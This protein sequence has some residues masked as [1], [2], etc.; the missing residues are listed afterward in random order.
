MVPSAVHA[1]VVA[2]YS[3][4]S[5]TLHMS[6][7]VFSTFLVFKMWVGVTLAV[8]V[9][10]VPSSVR[11]TVVAFYSNSSLTLHMSLHVFCTFFYR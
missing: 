6:L 8:V 4:S 10:L 5:L 1:T 11:A 2:F 3:N 7:N 9:E